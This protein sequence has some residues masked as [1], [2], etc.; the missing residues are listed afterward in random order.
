[1]PTTYSI[2]QLTKYQYEPIAEGYYDSMSDAIAAM[3]DLEANLG[4]RN[5]RVVEQYET[6]N[7]LFSGEIIA[8][9]LVTGQS[10][11]ESTPDNIY[12]D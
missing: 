11:P 10:A 8:Y 12:E 6:D 3:R 1:M 9:G 7:A 5:L 4:W 2:Q